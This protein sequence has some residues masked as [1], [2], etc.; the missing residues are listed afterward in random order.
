MED[1][2]GL[3]ADRRQLPVNHPT[4]FAS[5]AAAAK[6]EFRQ[7]QGFP[8][9]NAYV[10]YLRGGAG[11]GEG[12]GGEG[13]SGDGERR[14]PFL[15]CGGGGEE[16][17]L[18]AADELRGRRHQRNRRRG[19]GSGD[20]RGG[21]TCGGEGSGRETRR[22]KRKKGRGSGRRRK[23]KR[24]ATGSGRR[25]PGSPS[26]ESCRSLLSLSLVFAL[27]FFQAKILFH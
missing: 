4:Q 13:L 25:R 14:P 17:G 11:G 18:R 5:A 21:L 16:R 3:V 22:T 24:A 1:E 27:F 19:E 7:G 20:R 9:S 23:R 15:F 2:R 12:G 8:C 26:P 10:Y 6:V